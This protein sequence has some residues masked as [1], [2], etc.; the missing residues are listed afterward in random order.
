MSFNDVETKMSLATRCVPVQIVTWK[1]DVYCFSAFGVVQT[2]TAWNADWWISLKNVCA[3]VWVRARTREGERERERYAL[4]D[5]LN[6]F[7]A[8]VCRWEGNS[9][10]VSL[11][12]RRV[13]LQIHLLSISTAI[14]KNTTLDSVLTRTLH[15]RCV[16]LNTISLWCV[17]IFMKHTDKK[18]ARRAQACSRDTW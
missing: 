3:C 12:Y 17:C 10:C 1:T 5:L 18:S 4:S 2:Q 13:S 9:R 11:C 14:W 15:W 16:A 6:H 7:C 8:S